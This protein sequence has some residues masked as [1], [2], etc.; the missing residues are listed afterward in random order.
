M[1]FQDNSMSWLDNFDKATEAF[2]HE[3]GGEIQAAVKDF[4]RVDQGQLRDSWDYRIVEKEYKVVVGSPLENAIWEEYGT[5]EYAKLT[6]HVGRSGGWLVPADKLTK[7]AKSKMKKFNDD[8]YFTRGKYPN[9]T[10]QKALDKIRP[11][12]IKYAKDTIGVTMK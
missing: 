11:K 3:V 6:G 2:L 5:G 1:A 8:F 7:K 9:R 4:T 10:L 12:I